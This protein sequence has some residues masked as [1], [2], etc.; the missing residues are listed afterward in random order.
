MQLKDKVCLI[1]GAG[2]GIGRAIATTFAREG[3]RLVLVSRTA[4]AKLFIIYMLDNCAIN[5]IYTFNPTRLSKW[6]I[7]NIKFAAV[8]SLAL[9]N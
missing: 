3:A 8:I 9:I 6:N 7:R 1:T 2:K 4:S 5:R